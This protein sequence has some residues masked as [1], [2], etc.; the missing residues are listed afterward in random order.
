MITSTRRGNSGFYH[1]LTPTFRNRLYMRK[2]FHDH[3]DVGFGLSANPVM[4]RT[5]RAVD[6]WL[7]H[8]FACTCGTPRPA[9]HR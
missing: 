8:V 5:S 2:T 3:V 1:S 6:V 9:A 4:V 7:R